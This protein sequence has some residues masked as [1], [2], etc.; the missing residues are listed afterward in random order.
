MKDFL[1]LSYFTEYSCTGE[2]SKSLSPTVCFSNVFY[3][4]NNLPISE[5]YIIYIYKG[6]NF[7][8]DKRKSNACFLNK[9]ELSNHLKQAQKLYNFNFSIEDS[10]GRHN[11]PIFKVTL[12]LNKV[13]GNFHKYLLTW[14]RYTYE[15]PFNVLLLD[16]Y[17]LKKDN[18]FR[19][20]S[21]A[22]IFNLITSCYCDDIRLV[23]KIATDCV[24]PLKKSELS[25]LIVECDI[26]NNIYKHITRIRHR[27]IPKKIDGY[28]FRDVE[29][30]TKD[31]FLNKRKKVYMNMYNNLKNR[32]KE[33]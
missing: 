2:F 14:L 22:N 27:K 1:F 25:Q 9:Y 28:D 16:A 5:E 18:K 11:Y 17:W 15:F 6:I 31:N 23:H 8:K 4:V 30:W 3:E 32:L 19:F 12:S 33:I 7:L 20:Q 21:I 10:I 13:S 26:L 29:Y 24:K